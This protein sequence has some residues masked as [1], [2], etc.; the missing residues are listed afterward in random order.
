MPKFIIENDIA[1]W[2]VGT[3]PET[4]WADFE[5]WID[6]SDPSYS[7]DNFRCVTATDELVA[8]V[9]QYGGSGISWGKLADGTR[10]TN[11]QE[12]ADV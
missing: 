7:R 1:I 9:E 6:T 8:L 12:E 5:Q 10:C 2:G 4:A 11:E 3:T